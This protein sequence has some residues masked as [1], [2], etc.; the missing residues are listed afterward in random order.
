MLSFTEGCSPPP[1]PPTPGEN[2]KET[3]EAEN[4]ASVS[5]RAGQCWSGGSQSGVPALL[6]TVRNA[7]PR[8]QGL[9]GGQQL[10]ARDAAPPAHPGPGQ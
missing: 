7:L 10:P 5:A 2:P 4:G 6:G 3:R 8:A 9:R 1:P